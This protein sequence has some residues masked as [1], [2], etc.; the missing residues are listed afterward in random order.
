MAEDF[1][2]IIEALTEM[3]NDAS[4]PRNVKSGIIQTIEA[5]K[6]DADQSIRINKALNKLEEL[7]EDV[8]MQP[9][10]RTQIFNV[11]SLLEMI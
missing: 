11:V 2:S 6:Q 5:L 8:N 7:T 4:V 9:Y 3:Q 1:T 10:T